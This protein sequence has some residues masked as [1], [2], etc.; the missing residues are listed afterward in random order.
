MNH[1]L[2][3]NYEAFCKNKLLQGFSPPELRLLYSITKPITL[4][5]DD[6]LISEGEMAL[7][8]FFITKGTLEIV[9][10]TPDQKNNFIIDTLS[11][12]EA[13]GEIAFIDRGY[14]SASVRA[15]SDAIVRS[16]S[17][18]ELEKFLNRSPEYSHLYFHLSRNISLRLRS[19]NNKTL[20]S[21]KKEVY[22]NKTR[23]RMGNF[24]IYIVIVL[25]LFSYA[26]DSL[27]YLIRISPNTTLVAFPFTL[28]VGAFIIA[29]II[30][31]KISWKEFGIG[32]SNWK[33]AIYDGFVLSIPM[34]ISMIII[35]WLLIHF[36]PQYEGHKIFEPYA[37]ILDPAQQTVLYW[38]GLN[39]GYWFIA[40]PIQELLTR[41]VL[42]G[43]FE[44]F[45]IGKHKILI[46]ILLSN[47]IFSTLHIYFSP[48]IGIIVFIGGVY[49][50]WVYSRSHN[51]ISSS[52]SHAVLGTWALSVV[53]VAIETSQKI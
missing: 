16:I 51:L 35:K 38:L 4:K 34:M 42:Q 14:R 12:G 30:H 43:L 31:S 40:V 17:F 22:E 13:V 48:V 20:E 7:E 15:P 8:L 46:S 19:I 3:S 47:L 6:I 28:V 36:L 18:D 27:E 49:F 44:H 52:I 37:A 33:Q 25:S 21:L 23:V 32:L 2:D 26:L 5:K 24:L 45:F 9:K 41:G 1:E 10:H 11:A 29:M 50:G 39:A 53:G